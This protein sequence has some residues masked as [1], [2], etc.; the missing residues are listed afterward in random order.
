MFLRDYQRVSGVQGVDIEEC[1]RM[2]IL[3]DD[4]GSRLFRDDLAEDAVFIHV[5]IPL[6]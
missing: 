4:D 3:E 5:S 6:L 1:E 2:L